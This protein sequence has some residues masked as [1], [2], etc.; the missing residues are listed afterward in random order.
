[1]GRDGEQ[2]DRARKAIQA[3]MDSRGMSGNALSKGAGLTESAFRAFMQGKTRG[4]NPRSFV[5]LSEF[6]K[7]PVSDL[8][9]DT[10][11]T[12]EPAKES[13]SIPV[14]RIITD[15]SK[16]VSEQADMPV[17]ASAQG[18]GDG[19]ILDMAQI[20][21]WVKTP[22]PLFGVKGA[23][24]MY[25]IGDSMEPVYD[26]GD[27]LLIHPHKP[28]YKNDDVIVSMTSPDGGESRVLIKRLVKMTSDEVKLYQFNPSKE[29]SIPRSE[30]STVNLV[31]GKYRRR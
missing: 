31:V 3:L 28:V 22:A 29:F 6:L 1:M 10:P 4:M 24:G 18:G 25:V 11:P 21:E 15:A 20:I 8:L 27:M 7:V 17:Y 23:F 14:A 2:M 5:A 30:V 26:Q 19:I 13:T 16:L 12:A 9:G